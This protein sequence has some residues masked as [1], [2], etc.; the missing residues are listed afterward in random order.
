MVRLAGGLCLSWL[1]LLFAYNVFYMFDTTDFKGSRRSMISAPHHPPPEFCWSMGW[2]VGRTGKQI[3]TR[4]TYA[5]ILSF[6]GW[7]LDFLLNTPSAEYGHHVVNQMPHCD[8]NHPYL[9]LFLAEHIWK[10]IFCAR[11]KLPKGISMNMSCVSVSH[12]SLSFK[13]H[14]VFTWYFSLASCW[15][16]FCFCALFL[17]HHFPLKHLRCQGSCVAKRS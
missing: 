8:Q 7:R 14:F 11:L 15:Y 9:N 5:K 12:M 3:S 6:F 13:F 10:W 1:M 17:L 16:W 2:L 4:E